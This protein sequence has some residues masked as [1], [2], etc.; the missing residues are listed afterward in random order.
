MQFLV[1]KKAFLAGL[2]HQVMRKHTNQI[3]RRED[4]RIRYDLRIDMKEEYCDNQKMINTS[5]NYSD[6]LEE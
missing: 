5:H 3:D 2:F 6:Y 4:N 1:S